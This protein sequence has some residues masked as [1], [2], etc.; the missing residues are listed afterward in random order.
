M[1]LGKYFKE[2]FTELGGKVVLEDFYQTGDK[3]YSAQITKLK[4]QKKAPDLLFI[5]SGPDDVGTIVKQFRDGGDQD[6]R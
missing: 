5:S 3:D 6:R 2:R 1:L 4:A